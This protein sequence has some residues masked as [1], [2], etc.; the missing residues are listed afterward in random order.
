MPSN[1]LL[2]TMKSVK[3]DPNPVIFYFKKEEKEAQADVEWLREAF[4]R[5]KLAEPAEGKP[6]SIKMKHVCIDSLHH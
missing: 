1:S 3:F 5:L 2:L 4:E 6:K